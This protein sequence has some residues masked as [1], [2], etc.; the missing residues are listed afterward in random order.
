MDPERFAAYLGEQRASAILR[1][2]IESAVLPALE[3]AIAGGFRIVEVTLTTP[4]ALDAIA[5][6][7]RR[8]GITCGA[9]TVLDV[10]AAR[11][12][13]ARGARFLVSPVADEAVIAAARSL[14]VA[15]VAGAYTAAEFLHA[16]RAG[17]PLQKLFPAPA[18]GPDYLRAL[19]GPFPFLRVVPTS[20]VTA[21]NARAYLAAGAHALGFVN[22]LFDPADLAAARFF[23]I[24]A[25]ARRL[26]AIVAG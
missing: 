4:R 6:L 2:S 15:L 10:E 20:G 26:L 22:H 5:E 7:A 25:R 9:G 12:A 17:A 23:E 3:A 11:A 16:H 14:G 8:P 24:E 1:T 21:E 13:V 18:D 19:L